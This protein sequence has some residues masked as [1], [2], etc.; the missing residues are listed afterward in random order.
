MRAKT[1]ISDVWGNKL[2]L[3]EKK[4]VTNFESVIWMSRET[5]IPEIQRQNK[6]EKLGL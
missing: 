4:S 1:Q 6:E 3:S 5:H 2:H